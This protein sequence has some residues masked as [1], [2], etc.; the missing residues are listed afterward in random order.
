MFATLPNHE[1]GRERES[2]CAPSERSRSAQ[3][4]G[5]TR[6]LGRPRSD[7]RED[8]RAQR[9]AGGGNDVGYGCSTKKWKRDEPSESSRST[10]ECL[11]SPPSRMACHVRSSGPPPAASA[12]A[13]QAKSQAASEPVST[14]AP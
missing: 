11:A 9:D 3:V 6:R 14:S 12:I 10:L 1:A 5:R 13:T 2:G 7:R 4:D 8:G